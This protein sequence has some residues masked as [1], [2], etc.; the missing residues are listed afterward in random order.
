[1]DVMTTI[2]AL[3]KGLEVLKT[4]KDID[5]QFDRA[6]YKAQVAELMSTLAEAKVSLLD[7]REELREKDSE[8]AD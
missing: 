1:M 8:I 3:S 6:T 7:T 2:A 5:L 4:L